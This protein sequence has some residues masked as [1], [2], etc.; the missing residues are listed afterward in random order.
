VISGTPSK[1]ISLLERFET[2]NIAESHV[3]HES[4]EAPERVRCN[5]ERCSLSFEQRRSDLCTRFGWPPM[6]SVVYYRT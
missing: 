3:I 6:S 5:L 4:I 2:N 1:Q